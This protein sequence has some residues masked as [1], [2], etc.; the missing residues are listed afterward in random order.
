MEKGGM[1]QLTPEYLDFHL[2]TTYVQKAVA[3]NF[4]SKTRNYR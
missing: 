3:L 4:K 2:D 1:P